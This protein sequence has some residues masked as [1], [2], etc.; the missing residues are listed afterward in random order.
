[1]GIK[2]AQ[3]LSPKCGVVTGSLAGKGSRRDVDF[4]LLW[5]PV[6]AQ[7]GYM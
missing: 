1:M 4:F 6:E 2:M 5:L 7:G 3:V